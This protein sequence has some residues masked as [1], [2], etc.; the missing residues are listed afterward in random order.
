MKCEVSGLN[1]KTSK[2]STK[3]CKKTNII[4]IK[5]EINIGQFVIALKCQVKLTM[6][7]KVDTQSNIVMIQLK[8]NKPQEGPCTWE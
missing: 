5:K 3:E 1:L 8:V 7:Q 2:I 6:H 4:I